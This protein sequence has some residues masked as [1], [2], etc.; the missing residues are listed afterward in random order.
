[1]D[2]QHLTHMANRIGTFYAA[3]PDHDE[4]LAGIADHLRKFWEPRMRRQLLDAIDNHGVSDLDPLVA[5]A[6]STHRTLV[7]VSR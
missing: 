6:I 4:A 3:M 7:E 5:E 2:L 1:M